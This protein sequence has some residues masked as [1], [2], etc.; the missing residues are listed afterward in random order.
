MDTGVLKNWF[1]F[2]LSCFILGLI[3]FMLFYQSVSDTVKSTSRCKRL[4][5]KFGTGTLYKVT[6]R[7]S[8]GAALYNVTYNLGLRK[9][10]Q[11]CSC[12]TGSILNR[13][14]FPLRNLL[15]NTNTNVSLS[16]PC[17]DNYVAQMT[18]SNSSFQYDGY[19]ELADY[20]KN[21]SNDF[22]F[23]KP[24]NYQS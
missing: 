2:V 23:R 4:N 20:M 11:E 16:C 22:F 8:S 14:E 13:F 15:N 24:E 10:T 12:P 21:P 6:A 19:P 17:D 3:G 9:T 18:D 5:D 1:P 7:A